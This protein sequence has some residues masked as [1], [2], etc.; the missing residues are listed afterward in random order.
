ML[1][2]NI[3]LIGCGNWGKN[4]LRDLKSLDAHVTVISNNKTSYA[5]ALQGGA[6][7]IYDSIAKIKHVDGFIIATPAIT[8]ASVIQSVSHFQ[9]PIFVEKV[10][11]TNL[12]AAKHLA[13]TMSDR[14]FV[15]HKWRYHAG[16]QLLADIVRQK[17]LGALLGLHTTRLNWGNHHPDV[18]MMWT[19]LPHDLSISIE[20]F[21]DIP[22]PKTARGMEW[23]K[24]AVE[25]NSMLGEKPWHLIE[26]SSI[27][28]TVRRE[29]R[30]LCEN[31]FMIL[32]DGFVNAIEIHH[33]NNWG[34]ASNEHVE[35]RQF[36][37]EMPLKKELEIFLHYLNGGPKPP[38][39]A[40]EGLSVVQT[41]IQLRKM[42]GFTYSGLLEQEPIYA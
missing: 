34:L 2:K 41:I 17:E 36:D 1:Q 35:I 14:L 19:C 23:G 28:P 4:I 22:Q 16:I 11:T 42:A 38:T 15:M 5:N 32:Q 10:F 9:V 40:N 39:D 31:G 24:E 29:I 27:S 18:D 26:I 30:V 6:D 25:L 3:V 20:I 37:F 8:H 7:H 21:G 12:D 13:S 33:R